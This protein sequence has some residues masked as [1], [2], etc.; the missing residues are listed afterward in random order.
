MAGEVRGPKE[1][2]IIVNNAKWKC[3]WIDGSNKW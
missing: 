2:P 1:E 3:G